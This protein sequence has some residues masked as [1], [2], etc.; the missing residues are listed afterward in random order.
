VDPDV[1]VDTL[2]AS[3]FAGL[4]EQLARAV[5][6]LLE[7]LAEAGWRVQGAGVSTEVGKRLSTWYKNAWVL[8]TSA[9]GLV[10]SR[11]SGIT[12][13]NSNASESPFTR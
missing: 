1:V 7:E 13:G 3:T 12:K 2:R 8:G 11:V 5:R 4:D 6:G 9:A 10:R